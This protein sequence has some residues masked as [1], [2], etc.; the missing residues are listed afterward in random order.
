MAASG[1]LLAAAP[2]A[3]LQQPA[4]AAETQAH[5]ERSLTFLKDGGGAATCT[6]LND[7]FHNTD[8][9]NQPYT[10]VSS[11]LSGSDNACF[12]F[13]AMTI[14]VSYLDK[15]GVRRESS[16]SSF[17]TS[18]LQV[19]GTYSGITTSVHANWFDC[20]SSASA[21]CEATATANP[22]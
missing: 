1:L 20:D 4:G 22:K 3:A 19:G 9:P 11:G 18:V 16:T 6:V 8:D 2:V 21:T 15:N 7:A 17:G 10:L 5:G 13:V 12:D 14:T